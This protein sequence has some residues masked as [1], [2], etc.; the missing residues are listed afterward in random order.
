MTRFSPIPLPAW[1]IGGVTLEAL[2]D[3]I[4]AW[5]GSPAFVE[6]VAAFDGKVPDGELTDQLAYLEKF[7][8]VWD[9]RGGGE[10]VAARYSEHDEHIVI[11]VRDAA[12]ALG[13]SDRDSPLAPAY[14][15]VL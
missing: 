6:L 14:D 11:L 8:V 9:A 13:L 4:D 3:G 1:P 10:R 15:H 7:S 5:I 2:A 12:A